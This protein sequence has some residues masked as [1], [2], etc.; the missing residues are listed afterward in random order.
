MK[1]YTV[2]KTAIN[3]DGEDYNNLPSFIDKEGSSVTA[4]RNQSDVDKNY[5]EG[6]VVIFTDFEKLKEFKVKIQEKS[7]KQWP[8]LFKFTM[9]ALETVYSSINKNPEKNVFYGYRVLGE[10]E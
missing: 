8:G 4:V 10:I 3:R 6:N 5:L 2:L 9:V 7:E 1:K